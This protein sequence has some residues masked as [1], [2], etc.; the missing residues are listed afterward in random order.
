M[1]PPTDPELEAISAAHELDP[2]DPELLAQLPKPP[3]PVSYDMAADSS[4]VADETYYST[5]P[6]NLRT[7]PLMH[8]KYATRE[9][10]V[11]RAT[12]LATARG[13]TVYRVFYTRRAWVAH[14]RK[15]LAIGEGYK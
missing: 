8:E 7:I 11:A 15:P 13:E 6:P 1:P 12:E 14:V 2:L 4:S 5:E 3:P 10:A 9:A